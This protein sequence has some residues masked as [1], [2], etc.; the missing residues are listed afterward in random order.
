MMP[1][2]TSWLLPDDGIID[3]VAVKIAA[4]GARRVRL[5]KWSRP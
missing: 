2:Y 4:N 1:A 3:P 5:T